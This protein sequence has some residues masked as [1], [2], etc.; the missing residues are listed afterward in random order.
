MFNVENCLRLSQELLQ[1]YT[2]LSIAGHWENNFKLKIK[3][4]QHSPS[5]GYLYGLMED[6]KLQYSLSEYSISQTSL[7]QIFNDF[8]LEN[9]EEVYKKSNKETAVDSNLLKVLNIVT[10]K[11]SKKKTLV[12]PELLKCLKETDEH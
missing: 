4:D 2:E 5:I 9:E 1:S 8:A 6:R 10:K 7:E 3:K 12:N 11:L